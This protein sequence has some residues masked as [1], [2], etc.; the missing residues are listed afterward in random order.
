MKAWG[1]IFSIVTMCAA[2]STPRPILP[3]SSP[4]EPYVGPALS[5]PIDFDRADVVDSIQTG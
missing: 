3:I 4:I 2:C 5:A 1:L